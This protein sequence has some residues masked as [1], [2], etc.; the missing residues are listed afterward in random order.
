MPQC[1]TSWKNQETKSLPREGCG[2][3]EDFNG[4]WEEVRRFVV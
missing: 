2:F 3:S 4:G 1:S